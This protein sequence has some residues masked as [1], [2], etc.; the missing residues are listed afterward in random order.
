MIPPSGEK[1]RGRRDRD[2]LGFGRT[3]N[4]RE[5]LRVPILVA[6]N[7]VACQ[8]WSVILYTY[9]RALQKPA[10]GGVPKST[11]VH[12]IEEQVLPDN[13]ALEITSHFPISMPPNCTIA[14]AAIPQLS[15]EKLREYAL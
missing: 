9:N 8:H 15:C 14:V 1:S 4:R 12:A 10:L 6:V 13:H 7:F 5:L 2:R 11:I 3:S